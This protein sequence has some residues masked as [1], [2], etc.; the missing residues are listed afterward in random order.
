MATE[1]VVKVGGSLYD[2]PNLGRE[3]RSWLDIQSH[4]RTLLVPGGG[5]AAGLV[6][7]ADARDDI[8]EELCHWLALRSLAFTAH[9]LAA[10]LPGGHVINKIEQ[11][12]EAWQRGKAPIVD[13]Y[14]FALS[15]E[16]RPDHLPHRWSVTSDS[17]AARVCMVAGIERLILL[18][19]CS[20]P[21]DW[22]WHEAARRGLVDDAFP[23]VIAASG[24]RLHAMVLNWRDTAASKEINVPAT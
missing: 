5:A 22:S 19:S 13:M 17:L 11:R 15:D 2:V 4:C 14:A 1:V 10:R 6:R 21:G 7:E 20:V 18:K 12:E 9:V 16:A 24:G 3:L 8:G 23:E